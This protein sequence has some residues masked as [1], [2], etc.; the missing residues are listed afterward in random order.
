LKEYTETPLS[1]ARGDLK[2][3]KFACDTVPNEA[4]FHNQQCFGETVEAAKIGELKANSHQ[5][6]SN[7]AQV[8][9]KCISPNP[10]TTVIIYGHS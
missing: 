10:R 1:I 7:Y 2:L 3:A 6:V 5:G 4:A 8:N 9:L